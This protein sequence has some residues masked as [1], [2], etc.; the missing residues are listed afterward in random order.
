[1]DNCLTKLR[2]LSCCGQYHASRRQAEHPLRMRLEHSPGQGL[3]PPVKHLE[4]LDGASAQQVREWLEGQSPERPPL[5]AASNEYLGAYS[6]RPSAAQ[7]Y[8]GRTKSRY[9]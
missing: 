3:R 1:M 5:R 9:A 8:N 7:C 6:R 2:R 4:E